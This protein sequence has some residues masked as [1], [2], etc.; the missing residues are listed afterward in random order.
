MTEV[1]LCSTRSCG[2]GVIQPRFVNTLNF[3]M[4]LNGDGRDLQTFQRPCLP[5]ITLR[6]P[7]AG[8]QRI[9][10][11]QVDRW[12]WLTNKYNYPSWQK[13]IFQ[14][15]TRPMLHILRLISWTELLWIV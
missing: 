7:A 10:F 13:F 11:E 12:R 9:F 14:F 2:P 6:P 8:G 5:S 15:R 1:R 3:T 4:G